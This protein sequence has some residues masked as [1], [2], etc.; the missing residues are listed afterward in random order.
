MESMSATILVGGAGEPV[1]PVSLFLKRANRHGLVAGATG[2]GKTVTLQVLAEAFSRAGV[3][4]FAADVKGDLS[5]I[6]QSWEPSAPFKAR[7]EQIGIAADYRPEPTPVVY[8]D[9]FGQKGHPIRTTISEMGPTLLAR[10]MEVSDAQEG[11]LAIAFKM[12]DDEGLMLLDLKDLKAILDFMADNDEQVSRQYGLVTKNSIAALQRKLLQLDQSGAEPFFGEPAL[13]LNDF[14]R[15]DLSGRG[16]VNVLAAD[17]L[18]QSPTMYATFLLWMLSE[19]FEQL[20]EVGDPD[21][22]KLVFFFDEAHLL[23]RD[24]PKALLTTIEQVVRLIRSKGVGIYFVTQN[25]QDIPETVL[26]QL[27]NRFQHALRAY[28]PSEMKAV[29][30]AAESFRANPA[31]DTEEMIGQLGVG[32]ALVSVL[33]EKGVPT[34]VERTFIRPPVSRV[35]PCTDEE[36]AR[37]KGASPVGTK[38]D[39]VVDRESAFE[40]LAEKTE[41]AAE[42]AAQAKAAEDAAKDQER[43]ERAEARGGSRRQGQDQGG[44]GLLDGIFGSR[45][46]RRSPAQSMANTMVR[47]VGTQIGRQLVRGLLGSLRR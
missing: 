20:P 16:I 34:I 13:D 23:F 3:P 24:A 33:D 15:T 27:G 17:R 40:I 46:R 41:Q 14:M 2:T 47:E 6:S 5:G 38:Y 36:R 30:T 4:V 26:A 32:E 35:G 45:G 1:Q 9:L 19:L 29:K 7:A 11:A 42:A 21:K 39:T 18:I 22:P 28:T 25:P 10:L 12:A 37:V 31:F 8:W 44:G 43:Q